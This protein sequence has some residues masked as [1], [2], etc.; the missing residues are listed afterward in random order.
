[1]DARVRQLPLSVPEKASEKEFMDFPVNIFAKQLTYFE[2]TLFKKVEL[3]EINFWL[4]GN[5]DQRDLFAPN[6]LNLTLFVNRVSQWVATEIVTCANL[7]RRQSLVK[8]YINI[9][10]RRFNY[11]NYGGVL[12]IVMGLK[13]AAIERMKLTWKIP[14]KYLSILQAMSEVVSPQNNWEL[15]RKLVKEA[16][17]EGATYVPYIGLFLSDLTFI[18]DGGGD[19]IEVPPQFGNHY[20]WIKNSKMARILL[21]IAML[22]SR[23]MQEE[24]IPD[25][26]YQQYFA[27]ELYALPETE[28]F[29]KSR[30]LEPATKRVLT[31]DG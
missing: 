9:A 21:A 18:K 28:L 2:W 29:K 12:E 17:D 6:L 26:S 8:R 25:M 16:E 14:Q 15:W 31:S 24:I 22:Q 13:N 7:K 27:R 20:G 5:K 10:S 11:K 3:R 1:L 19:T 30:Q 4:K 23:D